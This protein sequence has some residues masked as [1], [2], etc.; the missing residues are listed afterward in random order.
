MRSLFSEFY[1]GCLAC[2]RFNWCSM[3]FIFMTR[4]FI[5]GFLIAFNAVFAFAQ[6]RCPADNKFWTSGGTTKWAS[7]TEACTNNPL[8]SGYVNVSAYEWGVNYYKC[9]QSAA[10]QAL[11]FVNLVNMCSDGSNPG[12]DG[13][14]DC[15]N[16]CASKAGNYYNNGQYSLSDLAGGDG[17]FSGS[18]N[19][20]SVTPRSFCQD[21][22]SMSTDNLETLASG[23]MWFGRG[24]PKYDGQ[25]CGP[26]VMPG[27]AKA[28][29]SAEYDCVSSGKGFG[30]VNGSVL[31]VDAQKTSEKKTQTQSTSKADGTKT[32]VKTDSAVK[33]DGTVCVT[34]ITTTTTEYNSSGVQ[35]A[36]SSQTQSTSKPDPASGNVASGKADGSYCSLNPTSPMCKSGSFTGSCVSEPACD[37]DPVTC[38]TAKATW[39]TK[40]AVATDQATVDKGNTALSGGDQATKDATKRSVVQIDRIDSQSSGASCVPDR[41]ISIGSSSFTI[42]FSSLCPGMDL[43]R[44]AIISIAGFTA[45]MIVVGGVK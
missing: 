32:D 4:N 35:T 5:V 44:V 37:G 6:N 2:N 22:C 29:P 28:K 17:V 19:T 23:S 8:L 45:L 39:M 16:P 34:T 41:T 21:G 9:A 3:D 38:A 14:C 24:N 20:P 33:C 1:H 26:G 10:G 30:Y 11:A 36:Q 12:S 42:P 18:T 27:T 43:M 31:C 40:C 13:M 7:P 25:Q 15:P